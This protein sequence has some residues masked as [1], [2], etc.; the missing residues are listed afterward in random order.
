MQEV[1]FEGFV[2][3]DAESR[4]TPK[5][6]MVT[7][8]SLGVGDGYKGED[9]QYVDRT[10]WV[11]VSVW[12]EKAEQLNGK[13]KK[14]MKVRVHGKLTFDEKTGN[15]RTYESNGVTKASFEMVAFGIK[16]PDSVPTETGVDQGELPF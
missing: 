12:G 4:Y 5:G 7:S 6:K 15:P 9:G 16:L 11:R 3:R 10:L 14:G 8:F 2:G 1:T 13:I